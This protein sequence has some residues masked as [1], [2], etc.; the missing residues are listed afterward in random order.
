MDMG[1]RH[2]RSLE[3]HHYMPCM[4]PFR[5]DFVQIAVWLVCISFECMLCVP[6]HL[7]AGR[8]GFSW[9]KSN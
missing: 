2:G 9:P 3:Q 6:C 5:S 4:H 1:K 7:R 8:G